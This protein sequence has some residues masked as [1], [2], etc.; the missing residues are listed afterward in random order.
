M[1]A[2]HVAGAAAL[3][4]SARPGLDVEELE[5]VLRVSSVD[6][7]EPGR[8]DLFGSG[9]VD[10]AAAVD[11]AVPDPLPDLEPAPG[12]TDPLKMAFTSPA[13]S[14]TQTSTRVTVSWT[15]SHEVVAGQL[16]RVQ[17]LLVNGLC[18]PSYEFP[19]DIIVLD[20]DSPIVETGL[21]AGACYR[22]MLLGIDE[23]AQIAEAISPPVRIVDRT[24]PAITSR[25][26]LP[27]A[28][29]VSRSANVRVTFSEPVRG[30]SS[31]TVR[32]KNLRTGFWVRA[33]VTYSARTRSATLDPALAMYGGDRYG[34]YL[35]NGIRDLSGNRLTPVSW[36][37][38]TRS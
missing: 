24:K 5:A 4:W 14:T 1:A 3:V 23:E 31:T 10:V 17:W 13:A 8:D 38:R 9:R 29:G 26:P 30:I 15:A 18:P 21:A 11:V 28:T 34:V 37:F 6:L 2:P 27:G 20:F 12:I 32:L 16:L 36:S 33:K 19:D 22:W 35:G 7:G 25:S